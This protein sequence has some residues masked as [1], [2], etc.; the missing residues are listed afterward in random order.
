MRRLC[1]FLPLLVSALPA[2]RDGDGWADSEELAKGFDPAAATSHPPAPRYAPVDLGPVAAHGTPVA[3]SPSAHRVLTDQGRIWS[4]QDG[5]QALVAPG[6][7]QVWYDCIRADGAVLGRVEGLLDG[8]WGGEVRVWVSPAE[9]SSVPGTRH[10]YLVLDSP[11]DQTW[12]FRPL[13]WLRG[14]DFIANAIPVTLE[15]EPPPCDVLVA[16]VAGAPRPA[17]RLADARAVADGAGG[18]WVRPVPALGAGATWCLEGAGREA[19]LGADVDPLAFSDDGALVTRIRSRLHWHAGLAAEPIPLQG[20]AARL[21]LT[22][23]DAGSPVAVE[24]GGAG[25]AWSLDEAGPSDRLVDLVDSEE[26][27]LAFSAVAVDDQGVILAVGT[28]I[29]PGRERR[30][31]DG[32]LLRS[33]LAPED[34][35]A[36]V[37]LLLPMRVRVDHERRVDVDG[38][39]ARF[40]MGE[41]G[42]TP[43]GRPLRL[44][45]NDDHDAGDI[46]EDPA[47]DL[48]GARLA[49][50]PNHGQH[51]VGGT[52]DLV[53]WFPV[54]LRIGPAAAD[55]PPFRLRLLAAES[56]LNAVATGLPVARAA[57]YLQRDLGAS[58]GPDLTQPLGRAEKSLPGPGG[59]I[60]SPAFSRLLASPRLLGEGEATLLVE[61]VAPGAATVWICLVREGV[62]A[63]RWPLAEEVLV[64]APLRVAVHPV[65]DFYRCWDARDVRPSAPAEPV[66]LPDRLCPGPW[67]V[68][69]HGFNVDAR[70]GRA[71]GAEIFKRLHQAGSAARFVAFRWFGDQGAAN[72]AMAVE[73]APAAADRLSEQVRRLD[74]A[75]PGR[76]WVLLGH[77]LGGYVTALAGRERLGRAVSLRQLVLVDAA[78]PAEA[79]DPLAPSRPA[80]YPG[81]EARPGAELMTPH[82]GPWRTQPPWSWPMARA[83]AWAGLFPRDDLRST[84][85]WRGRLAEGAPV[86]NLYSRSEDVL[87]PAPA[88]PG[89][90]PGLLDAADHGAWIYA[91]TRKGRWPVAAVNP[92]RAQAGWSL[93]TGSARRAAAVLSADAARRP[94]LLRA[95]P[96]FSA[97]RLDSAL[98]S[99]AVGPRSPGSQT[100]ARR[101]QATAGWGSRASVPSSLG[102]TVRDEL[103]A[104]AV[105]AASHPAG[106][107]PVAG[108][109]N[110]RMDGAEAIDP[111]CGPLRPFPLGWPRGVEAAGHLAAPACVWRHSDWKNVAYP[112]VHP[113]FARIGKS[114]GL[115]REEPAP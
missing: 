22:C 61:G 78:L 23:D 110:F 17:G 3:L 63:D 112:Y 33:G 80:D 16:S 45:L 75:S 38:L 77:S 6:D 18:R 108:A 92:G 111:P 41:P 69:T 28:R 51:R 15:P 106:S 66:A 53:D 21:A 57:Q 79:L 115:T 96:L 91:E 12:Q 32:Q 30:D 93:A 87:M 84:C 48:P 29:R 40:P 37:V 11:A 9:I 74:R 76:P 67:L 10:S 104:H 13:R 47:A 44:W 88:D 101:I 14:D 49:E 50:P 35:E 8:E 26:P 27:W 97:F 94:L 59:I 73:C 85:A 24:L 68:F 90:W 72:Y 89:R 107:A 65:E 114:A 86:L 109:E 103:L 52:A 25:R 20:D 54:C 95:A 105:P 56:R 42:A 19:S 39:R 2:D 31:A 98:T 82:A 34:G 1:F 99:P 64:R 5:W 71:W 43:S 62:P 7:L 46:S 81:G 113:V 100:V 58:H 4:W 83:D 102:W 60:L 55:L 36:R 70:L